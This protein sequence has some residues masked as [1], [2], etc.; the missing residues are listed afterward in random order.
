M[1]SVSV[2]IPAYRHR[3]F[4]LAKLDSVF[5]QTF[6]DYEVIVVHDGSPDDTGQVLR[7]LAEMGRIRYFEQENE[8]QAIARNRGLAEAKG[9]FIAFLDDDDLWPPNKLQWQVDA[10]RQRP[11]VS[12][13]GG[14]C[15]V[16]DSAGE[17]VGNGLKPGAVSFETLFRG[18]PFYSPG[19]TL[20]RSCVIREVGGFDA[21]LRGTDDWDLWFR[22]ARSYAILAED[23]VALRYRVHSANASRDILTMLWNC[24]RVANTHLLSL[25]PASRSRIRHEADRYLYEYLAGKFINQMKTGIRSC[26]LART[27]RGMIGTAFFAACSVRTPELARMLCHDLMPYSWQADQTRAG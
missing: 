26:R 4:I 1:P 12:V 20:I 6:T 23:I 9:E 2:L 14:T 27:A 11:E 19:Q 25:P 21:R 8:G 16:I 13:I 7:P 5:A 15:E 18:N 17:F 22:L 3:D 10:L 24:R